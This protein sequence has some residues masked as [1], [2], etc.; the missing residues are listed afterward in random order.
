MPKISLTKSGRAVKGNG[1]TTKTVKSAVVIK[2][3]RIC[4]AVIEIVGMPGSPL[5]VH[6]WSASAIKAMLDRQMG[7]P[8]VGRERRDPLAEFKDSLYYLPDNKGF[9][10]PARALKASIITSAN[11][12]ELVMTKC[13]RAIHAVGD[14]IPIIA[15]PLPREAHTDYDTRYAAD[16]EFY[17][18]H[19]C[20]M[21]LDL[22]H[23]DNGS[24]DLRFRG[25]FPVWSAIVVIEFNEAMISLDQLVNLVAAAGYG[26]G[27]LEGRPSAPV[28]RSGESGRFTVKLVKLAKPAK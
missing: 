17:H 12:M 22:V 28:C 11:D 7:E 2:K 10:I 19:G 21:R 14:L 1:E 4:Q 3:L 25:S 9:G 27:L 20:S 13:K 18:A 24:A 6:A 23:L 15:P 16:L 5:T 8:N 26:S